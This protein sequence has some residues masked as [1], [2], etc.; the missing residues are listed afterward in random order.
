MARMLVSGPFISGDLAWL[1]DKHR[2]GENANVARLCRVVDLSECGSMVR[3][4]VQGGTPDQ[5]NFEVAC[6]C[7][8]PAISEEIERSESVDD[9]LKNRGH[10]RGILA[11][12][13]KEYTDYATAIMRDAA[14]LASRE[15]LDIEMW[16]LT[17]TTR[18]MRRIALAQNITE[19]D[20]LLILTTIQPLIASGAVGPRFTE[21]SADIIVDF[22]YREWLSVQAGPRCD[23]SSRA[24]NRE[25]HRAIEKAVY[26]WMFESGMARLAGAMTLVKAGRGES[27][28]D[29]SSMFK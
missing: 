23:D 22:T 29:L 12:W 3:V 14:S 15:Q 16:R 6:N 18:A 19:A 21:L 9:M 27:P 13:E 7:L 4:C 10:H 24:E 25:A 20:T 2:G 5:K 8:T 17:D 28:W 26:Q 11:Y 1:S